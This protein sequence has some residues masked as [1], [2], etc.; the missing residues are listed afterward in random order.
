M[1]QNDMRQGQT[2]KL[3]A[4][5]LFTADGVFEK[6]ERW[7]SLRRSGYGMTILTGNSCGCVWIK[8]L[9]RCAQIHKARLL[10][11]RTMMKLE[12]KGLKMSRGRT[13]MA[14]VKQEF[15]FKG[16]RAKIQA[17]LEAIIDAMPDT[18]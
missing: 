11:L 9:L 14:I 4:D 16:N 15:G 5:L 8:D 7:H 17:Q 10:A 12:A 1:Y 13:A 6:L 3:T 2:G 18:P